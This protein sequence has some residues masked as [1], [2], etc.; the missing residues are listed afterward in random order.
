MTT[1]PDTIIF[2]ILTDGLENSS[3]DYSWVR[4]NALITEYSERWEFVYLGAN[5]DAIAEGFRLAVGAGRSMTYSQS[6]VGMAAAFDSL[7]DTTS[8]YRTGSRTDMTWRDSDHRRQ[9]DADGT[10]K[11]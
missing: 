9:R 6:C 5:Q 1:Q 7:S 8:G 3:T 11:K 10:D 2:V 4:V